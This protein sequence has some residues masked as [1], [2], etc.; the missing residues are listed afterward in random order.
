[1]GPISEPIVETQSL[2]KLQAFKS[3]DYIEGWKLPLPFFYIFWPGVQRLFIYP[4]RRRVFSEVKMI[5]GTESGGKKWK[6]AVQCSIK[7][8][9]GSVKCDLCAKKAQI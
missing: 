2:A 1:M 8:R 3:P 6:N 7:S 9:A 5:F 4:A